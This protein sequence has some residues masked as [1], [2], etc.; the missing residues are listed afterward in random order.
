MINFKQLLNNI[1]L[2][3]QADSEKEG[4]G[5]LPHVGEL[6]YTGNGTGSVKHLTH[7]LRTLQGKNV[8]GG[9]SQ[10]IDGK[11]SLYFGKKEG[12]PY[13]QYKG[14]G[15]TPFSSQEAIDNFV[16]ETGKDYLHGVFSAGLN[17]AQHHLID[18]NTTYQA[19]VML[20][21]D[22][23]HVK[24][25]ILHYLKPSPKTKAIFAV[26]TQLDSNTG[27]KIKYLPDV[28]HLET[29]ESHFPQL[30]MKN[31]L[32]SVSP[33]ETKTIT[34]NIG[35]V[36][37]ILQD[38]D[39]VRVSNEIASHRDPSNQTGHRHLHFVKFSNKYQNGEVDSR[40]YDTLVNWTKSQIESA[41]GN[42]E[43]NRIRSHLDYI[44][45]NKSGISKLL[46]AHV[47]IDDASNRI[48]NA[49]N[50]SKPGLKPVDTDEEGKPTGRVNYNNSEGY[51][52]ELPGSGGQVKLV[53]RHF[54]ITNR[55][56]SN[57]RK[58]KPIKEEM[59]AGGLGGGIE[60][61]LTASSGD[62]SGM[63]Y[64]LKDP[65]PDDLKISPRIQAAYTAKNMLAASQA[66]LSGDKVRNM[67][68]IF[69]LMNVGREAY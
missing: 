49:L 65:W 13:V 56:T 43:K 51:V 10:K 14:S 60:K 40:D 28:S 22:D 46:Q 47:H 3:E 69:S 6:L 52:S 62:I 64:N 21:H 38:D 63:G 50:R 57:A 8:A 16:K 30:N 29:E 7:G 25:N 18:D 68:K 45:N 61:P 36:S 55:R 33:E 11:I 53:P 9:L 35:K 24:G 27:K 44:K 59:T 1:E 20:H 34:D 5:H 41:K 32:H 31:M 54:S 67:R 12:V 26:H 15:A 48:I 42:A 37:N 4:I 23:E 17:A 2:V 19:D 58:V 66:K 39:V